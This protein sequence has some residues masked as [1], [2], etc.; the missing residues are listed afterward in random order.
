MSRSLCFTTVLVLLFAAACS[1]A[2]APRTPVSDHDAQMVRPAPRAPAGSDQSGSGAGSAEWAERLAIEVP[3]ARS[4]ALT[5]VPRGAYDPDNQLARGRGNSEIEMPIS[6]EEAAAL[7]Q[8]AM[9]QAPSPGVQHAEESDITS[10]A[11]SAGVGFDS[12]NFNGCCGGGGSVPPDPELAVGPDHVIAVV[13]IA[14]EIYDKLGTSLTGGSITFASFFAAV[15]GCT[16][17]FD[18]N[19]VYD[20]KEDRFILGIDA[21]GTDYC[22][23]ASATG[24]PLGA[25]NGYIIPTDIAGAFFDFPHLGVGNEAIYMGSNQFGGSVPGGFEGRAW[26]LDKAAMYTAAPLAVVSHSTGFDGTVQPANLHGWAQSTWPAVGTVH[27]LMTE[28]FDGINHTV[29]SWDDPFGGDVFTRD[30]DVDLATAAGSPCPGQS[31]F[32]VDV[33]QLGSSQQLQASDFRGLDTEYRNGYLWTTQ[34]ISVNPGGG[35]VDAVRWAQIDPTGPSV[36]Q[37]GVYASNDEY[38]FFP[39]LAANH[40]DDM[41]VGYSKSSTSIYPAVWVTGRQSGDPAGTLQAE[42]QLKAGELTYTSFEGTGPYRWGDYTGMTIDPDGETFWYLGEYSRNNGNTVG[43]PDTHWGTY[44]GSFSYPPCSSCGNGV[45]EPPAEQCDGNDL[46]GA[47]CQS[48]GYAFGT[49]GCTNACGYDISGCVKCS[50][51]VMG[52]PTS[53]KPPEVWSQY[54]DQECRSQGLYTNQ[55]DVSISC[56]NGLYRFAKYECCTQAP[57]CR[58]VTLGGPTSCKDSPTWFGYANDTCTSMGLQLN[59]F[60]LRDSCGSG[61]YRYTDFKCCKPGGP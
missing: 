22:V 2:P 14:F 11:P 12:I 8:K 10:R 3:A 42:T 57:R 26:A 6:P 28:V 13:N 41:A 47:T 48:L 39:D 25:W 61:H 38:R 19:V 35:T 56:G 23:A 16:G 45:Y 36:V 17:V 21:N 5:D 59:S 44:I 34:T 33:P 40:C 46:G 32:P 53:C 4:I 1:Q 49:L 60:S 50:V 7:R 51:G 18:P 58:K 9:R 29:W 43:N 31:C 55:F 30:G 52:G 54:V 27:Y 15:P 37:A 20:E 24:D